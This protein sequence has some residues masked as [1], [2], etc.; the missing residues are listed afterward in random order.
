[1]IPFAGMLTGVAMTVAA[2]WGIV[3]IVRIRTER[4]APAR[5]LAND[6]AVLRDQVE[7]LHQALVEMQDRMDFTERLL[8]QGRADSPGGA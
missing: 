3:Q 8:T 5:E 7:A 4:T 2:V 1:M 6:V